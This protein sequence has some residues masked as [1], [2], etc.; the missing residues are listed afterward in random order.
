MAH[1]INDLLK[2]FEDEFGLDSNSNQLTSGS[3][4]QYTSKQDPADIYSSS[5][6]RQQQPIERT[7][8]I[9]QTQPTPKQ[10]PSDSFRY[11]SNMSKLSHKSDSIEKDS[12]E[13][14]IKNED[15]QIDFGQK[16]NKLSVE[17]ATQIIN[18]LRKERVKD[19]RKL[20]ELQT[21]NARLVAKMTILE[22]TD[23]KVA[24]LGSRV[25]Q[26]LQ[27]YL[28]AEQVRTQQVAQI[29]QLK[30]ECIILKSRL[31]TMNPHD[32]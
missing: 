17:Q 30:Q 25:E 19:A 15:I 18:E 27:K 9:E 10:E 12:N 20:Q 6:P 31:S 5:Y 26:L 13:S 7:P 23:L 16:S 3:Q 28:E 14:E 4:I 8:P 2:D 29:S 22:H 24:E 11:Q 32:S 1:L 21:E